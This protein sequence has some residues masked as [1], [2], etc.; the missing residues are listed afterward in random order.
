M[1]PPRL[2]PPDIFFTRGTGWLSGAI[3]KLTRS[4]GEPPTIA[5]HV[6]L[7]G[8]PGDGLDT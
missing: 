1:K 6:G 8:Y 7:I 3:R 5:N 4:R 2:E